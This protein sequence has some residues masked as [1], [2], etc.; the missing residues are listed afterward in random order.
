MMA[1][2]FNASAQTCGY[3][4]GDTPPTLTASCSGG[5]GITY[6]WESPSN[7]VSNGATASANEAGLWTWECMDASGC[8]ATG[9]Y[10]VEV[11]ADPLVVINAIDVC[12]GTSQ[13]ITASNVPAGYTYAWTF[14]SGVPPS[15]TSASNS[16]TWNTAGT[17]TI[18][19]TID[20]GTC[21]WTDTVDVTR[22]SL[23]GSATC[24]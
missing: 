23:T 10:T 9:T 2:S 8:T 17:Y 22:G 24:N 12:I 19:L 16:V 18:S 5:T 7:V 21:S 14:P 4:E 15:S 20:N 3:C 1:F 6:T 13:V 11:E